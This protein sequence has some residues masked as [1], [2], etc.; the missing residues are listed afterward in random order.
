MPGLTQA[1]FLQQLKH[2]RIT[3][4]QEKHGVLQIFS[5]GVI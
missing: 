4:L 2:E 5:G 1:Q 3:E